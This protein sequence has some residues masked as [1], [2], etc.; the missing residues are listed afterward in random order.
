MHIQN[1]LKIKKTKKQ[2]N[3]RKNLLPQL[4][5]TT[6]KETSS[7]I[8]ITTAEE[9]FFRA[10]LQKNFFRESAWK[11]FIPQLKLTTVKEPSFIH[12]HGRSSFVPLKQYSDI[13]VPK[14]KTIPTKAIKYV[15]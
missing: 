7:V 3:S 10:F 9:P 1:N 14:N 13:H 5:I 12:S 11:N 15:P 4:K 6:A 2:I 8:N